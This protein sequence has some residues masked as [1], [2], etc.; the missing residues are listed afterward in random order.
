MRIQYSYRL[1]EK[2]FHEPW[3]MVEKALNPLSSRS[4]KRSEDS[5]RLQIVRTREKGSRLTASG[6]MHLP[7]KNRQRHCIA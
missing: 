6:H 1:V 2:E 3:R 7:G 5:V 4:K